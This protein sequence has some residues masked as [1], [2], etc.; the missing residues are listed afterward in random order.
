MGNACVK[1]HKSD[2]STQMDDTNFDTLNFRLEAI[3]KKLE[4][5]RPPPPRRRS[6]PVI[7][8]K[9]EDETGWSIIQA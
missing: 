5:M 7:K 8:K 6:A 3:E 4:A 1:P 2:A 9:P